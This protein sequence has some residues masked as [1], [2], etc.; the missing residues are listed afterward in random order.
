MKYIIMAGRGGDKNEV[1]KQLWKVGGEYIIGRTIRLLKKYGVTDICISTHDDRFK[2]FGCKI[3]RHNNPATYKQPWITAFY[4][5]KE[6]CCYVMGDVVFSEEAIRTIVETETDSI[7]FFASAPPFAV[8]YPKRWAEPFA[9]KVVDLEKFQN[10]IEIVKQGLQENKWRRDPIA[11]ELWQVIKDTPWNRIDYTNYTVINDFTCDVDTED[12]LVYYK[13]MER[14]ECRK[15]EPSARYMIHAC[16][17]RMWYVNEHLIPSML[18]QGISREQ[19]TVWCDTKQEGNLKACMHAFQSL[20]DDNEGTWHLQDDVLLARDFRRKTERYNAGLVAGFISQRY[21]AKAKAGIVT[22]ENAPWSFPCIRIPNKMARA[23]AEWTLTYLVGNPVYANYI[24]DGNGDDWAFKSFAKDYCKDVM[25]YNL[26]PS[27][28][29]H[30]DNLIGGSSVG[31]RR[32]GPTYA[33]H[34]EDSDL[35]E[36]LRRRI[37]LGSQQTKESM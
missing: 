2:Q 35:V 28:V 5:S 25:C 26:Q 19:I 22:I 32:D 29:E 27:I 9:F 17:K 12:N 6:P 4:P 36:E 37:W 31:T 13:N 16:P 24:G 18:E 30:I 15:D 10:S 1:P 23:C 14:L 8:D 20:P 34:F 33:K 7:E 3:L 21:S 11:W